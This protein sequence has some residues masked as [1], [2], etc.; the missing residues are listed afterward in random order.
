MTGEGV[1]DLTGGVFTSLATSDILNKD[2]FWENDLK[3]VNQEFLFSCSTDVDADGIRPNHAYSVADVAEAKGT[4]LVKIK[5][6]HGREEWTGPWA[7]GSSEWTAELL[8]L[9]GHKF[10]DDGVFWIEYEDFLRKFQRLMRIRLFDE[11]WRIAAIWTPVQVPWQHEYL[12]TYFKF[13]LNTS[14]EIVIVLSQLDS[15][16]YWGLEGQYQFELG[17]QLHRLGRGDWEENGI[18]TRLCDYPRS[19]NVEI[20][21][22][23]GDYAV[24]VKIEATRSSDRLPP[25]EVVRQN[26]EKRKDKLL[27]IG[28]SYDYANA[29]AGQQQRAMDFETP[30]SRRVRGGAQDEDSQSSE[31]AKGPASSSCACK[32]HAKAIEP[33]NAAAV[34]GLRIYHQIGADKDKEVVTLEVVRPDREDTA[35]DV[36][37][38]VDDSAYDATHP[39]KKK[40]SASSEDDQ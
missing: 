24:M 17:F 19:V 36:T 33:W 7:D 6:P 34:I 40:V 18:V 39:H 30:S 28:H 35:V 4:R 38:D 26:V 29:K 31:N 9:L 22:D 11:D 23:A 8:Q 14:G 2:E 32:C 27:K 3:H 12:D 10:G 20:N 1:E 15:R 16:Y 13:T 5:N 21:L 37:M 25:E